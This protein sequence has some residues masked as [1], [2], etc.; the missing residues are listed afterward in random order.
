MNDMTQADRE[1]VRGKVKMRLVNR[2]GI[3]AAVQS[4]QAAVASDPAFAPAQAY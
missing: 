3:D 1:V 4:F 2:E